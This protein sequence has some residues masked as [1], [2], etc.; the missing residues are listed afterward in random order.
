PFCG[1]EAKLHDNTAIGWGVEVVCNKCWASTKKC[2]ETEKI[3]IA[4]WNRR[5]ADE[6]DQ[7]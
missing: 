4:A 5:V 1:G 7:E 2:M 3:A 6:V